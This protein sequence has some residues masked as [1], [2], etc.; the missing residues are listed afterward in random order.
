MQDNERLA[1]DAD[2]RAVLEY[3]LEN[4]ALRLSSLDEPV[5]IAASPNKFDD[6]GR[7]PEWFGVQIGRAVWDR[8]DYRQEGGAVFESSRNSQELLTAQ[9]VLR[10][11]QEA[12]WRP[13]VEK[14]FGLTLFNEVLA[15]IKQHDAIWF[16]I[17]ASNDGKDIVFL[18]QPSGELERVGA[19]VRLDQRLGRVR[20]LL[21]QWID[22]DT[23]P[24]LHAAAPAFPADR[25]SPVKDEGGRIALAQLVDHLQHAFA[26][27]AEL[28]GSFHYIASSGRDPDGS[29][30]NYR[31]AHDYKGHGPLSSSRWRAIAGEGFR[32]AQPG[33]S[34]PDFYT[35]GIAKYGEPAEILDAILNALESARWRDL[36]A[37]AVM[38]M[39]EMDPLALLRRGSEHWL[40]AGETTIFA[41][42][43]KNSLDLVGA[44][45]RMTDGEN[46]DKA[47]I[48]LFDGRTV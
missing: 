32:V 28:S 42:T 17:S 11:L 47:V 22:P 1:G 43:N 6:T 34:N 7:F 15:I 27:L 20:P 5:V 8:V 16:V 33:W 10:W 25:F 41:F 13:L 29:L 19:P 48:H 38:P 37:R 23:W 12:G 36:F 31:Y 26:K 14:A 24:K 21:L 2:A 4:A 39:S 9:D 44:C 45:D 3:L 35:R 30:D 46:A 40:I 18:L